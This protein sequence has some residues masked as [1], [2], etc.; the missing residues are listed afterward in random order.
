[1][2][3]ADGSG[4]WEDAEIGMIRKP[5]DLPENATDKHFAEEC[6]RYEPT[7][8]N[9]GSAWRCLNSAAGRVYGVD[10]LSSGMEDFAGF[11]HSSTT[12]SMRRPRWFP[13]VQP[14]TP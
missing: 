13:G 1:M 14:V 9:S 6:C 7:T 5:E 11:N 3:R 10:F 12:R 4:S 8:A 2:K